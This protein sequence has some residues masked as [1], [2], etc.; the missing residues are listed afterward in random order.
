MLKFVPFW[1]MQNGTW[2]IHLVVELDRT[3]ETCKWM[4]SWH[5][6]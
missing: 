3:S 1:S 4:S 5:T 2:H 6:W